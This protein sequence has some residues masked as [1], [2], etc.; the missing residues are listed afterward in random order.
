MPAKPKANAPQTAGPLDTKQVAV[1]DH[2]RELLAA[3][4]SPDGKFI[5]A[6]SYDG[7]VYRWDVA[8]STKV[9]F[10]GHHGW[11]QGMAFHPDGK[12]LFTGD[13]WGGICCWN[14]ADAAPK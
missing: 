12:R 5:F 2:D 11:I 6:G 9:A 3:R 10:T 7:N 14:Y 8:P 13:S 1:L 4:F